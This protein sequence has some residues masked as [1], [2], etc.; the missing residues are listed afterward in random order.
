MIVITKIIVTPAKIGTM[1]YVT[2]RLWLLSL[3]DSACGEERKVVS[4]DI[5]VDRGVDTGRDI[6]V[7]QGVDRGRE[8]AVGRG[9]DIG[10]DIAVDRGVDTGR[11]IAVDRGVDIVAVLSTKI[12]TIITNK[13]HH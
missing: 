3:F 12:K 11:D 5:A 4:K 10:E 8:V 6:A 2:G 1:I 7:D 13:M 9:V